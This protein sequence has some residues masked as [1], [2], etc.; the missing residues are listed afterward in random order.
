MHKEFR[1]VRGSPGGG[2]A[3][4]VSVEFLY[5]YAFFGGLILIARNSRILRPKNRAILRG[6]VRIAAAT[7][8]NNRAMLAHSDAHCTPQNSLT[9]AKS[10]VWISHNYRDIDPSWLA[11]GER[12]GQSSACP[13]DLCL[14]PVCLVPCGSTWCQNPAAS[15]LP[16]FWPASLERESCTFQDSR[17]M[18]SHWK[19]C[20]DVSSTRLPSPP[21]SPCPPPS[22][23]SPVLSLWMELLVCPT[24]DKSESCPF[25]KIGACAMTTKFLDN[26]IFI[27]KIL[28]SWRFPWKIAFRTIFPSAP[29]PTPPEKCKFYFYC[30]LAFSEKSTRRRKHNIN[31]LLG[32]LNGQG[33]V[34]WLICN[35]PKVIPSEFLYA[36]RPHPLHAKQLSKCNFL[37][38]NGLHENDVFSRKNQRKTAS[39][40]PFVLFSLSL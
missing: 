3:G 37:P 14:P 18:R 4:E 29:L 30:R 28:L 7:A 39:L 33:F 6:A 8:A 26:K 5:V 20:P 19:R 9:K 22:P 10:P 2:S 15:D 11:A 24:A 32:F 25:P 23:Y 36:G 13:R 21:P 40:A 1:G 31:N 27:F 35:D 17:P 38:P 12:R 34:P 16:P